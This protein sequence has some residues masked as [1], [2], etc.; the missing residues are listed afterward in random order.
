MFGMFNGSITKKDLNIKTG[1]TLYELRGD[2]LVLIED[3]Q[4]LVTSPKEINIH[5]KNYAHYGLIE[6]SW[7]RWFQM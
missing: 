5:D 3:V 7:T 4:N 2:I 1:F 6:L